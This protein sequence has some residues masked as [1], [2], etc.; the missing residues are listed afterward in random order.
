M[1]YLG[2]AL[3]GFQPGAT[4]RIHLFLERVEVAGETITVKRGIAAALGRQIRAR[5]WPRRRSH[6]IPG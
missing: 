6:F 5:G 1:I 2:F 3:A 4:P